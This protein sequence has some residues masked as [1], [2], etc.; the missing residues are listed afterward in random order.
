MELF[1]RKPRGSIVYYLLLIFILS[2]EKKGETD[3]TSSTTFSTISVVHS[4]ISFANTITEN[5]SLTYFK[6]PYIYMGSG[7]AIGDVNN[8]GLSDVFFTGNMVDNKL[9]LNKG[10]MQFE[11]ISISA[12]IQGDQRW[13]TGVTMTDINND[14][15]LDIYVSVSGKYDD[16]RN[17]L[18]LNNGDLT[19]T[20]QA[21]AYGIADPSNSIQSTFFDYDKDG[22]ID[23]FVANYP[24]VE[25]SQGNMFYAEK[26]KANDPEE[27]GHLY[28]NEGNGSFTDVTKDA[29]VQ[30]FGLT[31][32]LVSVDFNNDGWTDL[33]LSNDF[34]VPDYFYLNNGDG[35]FREVSKE[36]TGHTSMFGMGIDASDFNNDGLV[37]LIQA[38]MSP[39]DYERS[40]VNMAS[41]SPQ[42]FNQ[43][44]SLGFHYQYMQNSLQVN[45]GVD[46]DGLPIM[47]EISRLAG[48]ASTDWSWSTLFADLD[49]DGLKDI[50]ITNGMKLD[51][52]DNDIN[53]KTNPT[54][55]K[56]DF[57]ID[58]TDYNS[59]PI[60]NYVYQNQ[61]DFTFR[62]KTKDW[63]LAFEG[64]SNGMSY[65]DLDNDGDL[66]LVI[67]NI[68]QPATLFENKTVGSD[69]LRISL[70]GPKQNPMGLGAKV[71]VETTEN[72]Q[73]QE[74]TLTRGFQS[75]VDPILHFGLGVQAEIKKL[76]VVWPD[77]K[78]QLID[79]PSTNNLMVIDYTLAKKTI[80]RDNI[81]PYRFSD[82]TESSGLE[83]T[84]SEDL[85]DDYALEP[86]LPYKYSMMGPALAKGDINDDGLE[87]FFVGNAGGKPG[88]LFIQNE[89]SKFVEIE[90]PWQK[91]F[92][93]EDVAAV[94]FDFDN[95]GD[96]DLYVVS[97]GNKFQD[98]SDR[99]YLNTDTGFIK[100]QSSLP[101]ESIVGKAIAVCDFDKDGLN[102]IFIGGRNTPGKY[103]FPASSY[104]MKNMGGVD[105][106]LQFK[107]V[108]SDQ[109]EGLNSIGMVTDAVW[110]DID[111]NSWDDLILTGEWMPV[112]IFKNDNGRLTNI[113]E[114]VGLEDTQGWWY[115]IKSIDVDND[116]DLDLVAGNLGLNH[117]YKA[118]V[119]SPFEVYSADF[120]ENGKNDIVLSYQ[121]EGKKVPLRG[122]ECSSQQVPAIGKRYS[123][124]REYAKAD[125]SDIYGSGTLKKALHY[126]AKT[127]AHCWFENENGKFN[128]NHP[129]PVRTQFSSINDIEEIDYNGDEFID[130]LVVGNLYQAEV[131][132]PR[133]DSGLGLVLIGS[134]Q[135]F[136]TIPPEQSG[137][138]LRGDI[139]NVSP[140]QLSNNR[141]GY[142]MGTNDD[143]LRLMELT[144]K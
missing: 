13:Y 27:S 122:R 115:T 68:D 103:P 70:K 42:N 57:S 106:D 7:V 86:L 110:A 2:C 45:S 25:L 98:H 55:F 107:N 123:T 12:G 93:Q 1:L 16:T 91:D 33:Y 46:P 6:F 116:G 127:F 15:F 58:I 121:K 120:D 132:T 44:V 90:G 47:S 63:N 129:L 76:K 26:M 59:Q 17:Q 111:G 124:Y 89:D 133:S 77:G 23:L 117:K 74:L 100:A 102:D 8:D 64:F 92:E 79:N 5:D 71:V 83:F 95:D 10:N 113:T 67:N 125:L 4:G 139:K 140:I 134:S 118:S 35:T 53:N 101:L 29:G 82:I 24:L 40:R 112:T 39:E 138:L 37:D 81:S 49:N 18:F 78:V 87:D 41:M 137:L 50:Y 22:D 38:D 75:S 73:T 56:Q 136:Q 61:G 131:E 99:L 30:N 144:K 126:E 20:E 36:A 109:A 21:E 141:W 69:Y 11:D 135:G 43:G 128:K 31:L 34:N 96:N 72:I 143:Q 119:E 114:N 14:G 60:A 62:N 142:L 130:L 52:N 66:D 80:E 84:H 48:M 65:G 28:R 97:G 108:T 104:L 88:V 19:F 3:T 105:E 9:Y 94:I 54:S 51:V 85:F 32:G